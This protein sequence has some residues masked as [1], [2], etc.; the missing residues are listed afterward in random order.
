M[1]LA[2]DD[3]R[4]S[5]HGVFGALFALVCAIALLPPAYIAF[6]RQHGLIAAVPASIWYLLLVSAA[7]IAVTFGLERRKGALD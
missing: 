7:A 5:A 3:Q 2:E 6:S 1:G 4:S